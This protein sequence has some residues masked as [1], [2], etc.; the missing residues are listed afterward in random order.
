GGGPVSSTCT[1][2]SQCARGLTC[3]RGACRPFCSAP[4]TACNGASVCRQ[5][6]DGTGSP[7]P[8]QNVC[9]LNC[10]LHAPSDACGSNTCIWDPKRK[11]TDCDIPGT[12]TIYQDCSRYN[13]CRP[14]LACV[15]RNAL[16]VDCEPW[17]RLGHKED[18]DVIQFCKDV[19]GPDAP[20]YGEDRL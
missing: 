4:G 10:D 16:K 9:M 20:K 19:Y 18:C 15:R 2:T 11:S 7:V 14:G 17:C 8:N 12:K 13:D 6:V 1:T 5:E 3:V